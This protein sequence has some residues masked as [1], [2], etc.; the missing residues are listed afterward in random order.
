MKKVIKIIEEDMTHQHIL[1]LKGDT[2]TFLE[3]ANNELVITSFDDKPA[4]VNKDGTISLWVYNN[5]KHRIHGPAVFDFNG[6]SYY[7][8]GCRI[9]RYYKYFN[10][11]AITNSFSDISCDNKE[12]YNSLVLNW[13]YL[14]NKELQ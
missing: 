6:L 3:L 10:K 12:L 13:I 11:L 8:N 9:M 7:Y 2:V 1:L 4:I 5:K 14:L